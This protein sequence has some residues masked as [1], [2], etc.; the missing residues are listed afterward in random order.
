M[1]AT[2]IGLAKGSDGG[3][4]GWVNTKGI[5]TPFIVMTNEE[6]GGTTTS[7]GKKRKERGRANLFLFPLFFFTTIIEAVEAAIAKKRTKPKTRLS[8]FF[9]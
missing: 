6:K 4:G 7:S 1:W 2:A 9:F 5:A 8:I 3:G